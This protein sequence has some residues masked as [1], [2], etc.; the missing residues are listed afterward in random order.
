[1]SHDKERWAELGMRVRLMR[2]KRGMKCTELARLVSQYAGRTIHY[3]YVTKWQN[4]GAEIPLVFFEAIAMQ[5]WDVPSLFEG[6][7]VH[8]PIDY[9]ALGSL[10]KRLN[11]QIEKF[12]TNP[13]Q[14]GYERRNK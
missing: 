13:I 3:N 12:T 14:A 6:L 1:M 5:G 4:G 10:L 2:V 7:Q 9:F 11:I 8:P